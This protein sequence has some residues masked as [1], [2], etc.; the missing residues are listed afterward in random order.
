L[1]LHF[2]ATRL[3]LSFF[4]RGGPQSSFGSTGI[5]PSLSALFQVDL[6]RLLTECPQTR[7]KVQGAVSPSP[8]L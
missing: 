8:L 5:S 1:G 3:D 7:L 4:A 6:T 2:Q